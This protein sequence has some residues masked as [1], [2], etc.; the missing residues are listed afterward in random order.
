[1][2][3]VCAIHA[4]DGCKQPSMERPLTPHLFLYPLSAHCKLTDPFPHLFSQQLCSKYAQELF[5]YGQKVSNQKP[6]ERSRETSI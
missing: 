6:F 1:M 3:G 2:N 5:A 4:F